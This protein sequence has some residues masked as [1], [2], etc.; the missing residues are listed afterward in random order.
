MHSALINGTQQFTVRTRIR[1][2]T[3]SSQKY[4]ENCPE[5]RL[6]FNYQTLFGAQPQ[7]SV[8]QGQFKL[9]WSKM[10]LMR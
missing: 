7:I 3:E 5:P 1:A 8:A 6:A 4:T 10:N 9:E 2:S